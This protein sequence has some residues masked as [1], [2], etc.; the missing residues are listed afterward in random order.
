[1]QIPILPGLVFT[2]SCGALS[3]FHATQSPIISRTIQNEGHG[4]K[5]FYG[6]MIVEAVIAMVWAAATMSM[7]GDVGGL[8]AALKAGGP[9]YVVT[10]V[11]TLA[12]GAVGGTLAVFGVIVLPI[13]SGDTAFRSARMI[14]ADYL[15]I[16]QSKLGNRL[17]IAA[18]LFAAS[19]LLAQTDFDVLWRYFNWAN[20]CIAVIAFFVAARYLQ[21]EGKP[22]GIA[23]IPG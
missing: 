10:R 9:A 20:Q 2:I 6:M 18:P 23:L 14:I 16:P 13:T 3:G 17:W 8:H 7:F 12:L 11:S 5:V 1:E 15:Q 21:G 22:Y 4:R 19:I